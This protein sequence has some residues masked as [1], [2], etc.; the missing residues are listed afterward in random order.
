M[1]NKVSI[2]YDESRVGLSE[3]MKAIDK[4]GYSNHLVRRAGESP[5]R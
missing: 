2:D 1:L 4:A 5:T 3:I